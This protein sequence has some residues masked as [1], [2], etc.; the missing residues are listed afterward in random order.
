[1]AKMVFR[2]GSPTPVALDNMSVY[3]WIINPHMLLRGPHG[4]QTD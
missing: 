2:S 4:P 3:V 1:M